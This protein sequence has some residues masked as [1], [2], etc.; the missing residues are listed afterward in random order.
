MK[1]TRSNLL[2]TIAFNAIN[3]LTPLI[4][5]PYVSRVLGPAGLGN[6]G[7]ANGLAAYFLAFAGI[8]LVPYGVRAIAVERSEPQKLAQTYS[9]LFLTQLVVSIVAFVAYIAVVLF[10]P[11]Y[12]RTLLLFIVV[13]IQIVLTPLGLDWFFQGLEEFRFIG[14]RNMV[15]QCANVAALFIFV[16]KPDDF[17]VY[18]GISTAMTLIYAIISIPKAISLSRF[19]PFSELNPSRHLGG[20]VSFTAMSFLIA[21]YTNA[22]FLA[23]GLL[24]T[25]EEAGYYTIPIKIARLTAVLGSSLSTVLLPKLSASIGAGDDDGV[26][27]MLRH[28]SSFLLLFILPAA[29]GIFCTAPLLVEIFGGSGYK[30]SVNTLRLGA[31]LVPAF[32]LQSYFQMQV[33]VPRRKEKKLL[34][35]YGVGLVVAVF[36]NFALTGRLGHNGAMIS[37][38][39]AELAVIA[40]ECSAI[41]WNGI[42]D[43]FD[44][45]AL[46]HYLCGMILVA[47]V[48]LGCCHIHGSAL[49]VFIVAA[50]CASFAYGMLLI[51][52]GDAEAKEILTWGKSIAARCKVSVTK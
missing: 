34:L 44:G 26:R 12:S 30:A 28:S 8:G 7:V 18:A 46:V 36:A 37:S 49:I 20:L 50:I 22:D 48:A 5:Y 11:V 13:G 45:R 14:I 29:A 4:T 17:V 42:L 15:L 40:V 1:S 19:A 2:Y 51:L 9:E 21:A 47:G 43:L 32:T 25:P 10:S 27:D 38:L 23:L 52:I 41:G 16:K 3:I 6:V 35:A 24:S 33:L 39:L 31:F